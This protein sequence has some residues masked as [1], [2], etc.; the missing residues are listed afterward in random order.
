[1]AFHML[2][3][4][5]G[6]KDFRSGISEFIKIWKYKHPTPYDLFAVLKRNTSK[7]IDWFIDQWFYQNG[8][9]DLSVGKVEHINDSISIEIKC[10]GVF[11]VPVILTL[12][13]EDETS[14][15]IQLSA[16]LWKTDKK[17]IYTQ[18]TDK[19]ISEIRLG[20]NTIPD[21]TPENNIFN[22]E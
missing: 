2:E 18:K 21:I 16:E 12:I 5:I 22:L 9:P 8:W 13:K 20:D 1:M 4:Y 3:L 19:K 6:R 10:D 17:Y 14:D 7:N 15:V 11:A